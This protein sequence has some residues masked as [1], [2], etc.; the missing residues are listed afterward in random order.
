MFVLTLTT[1]GVNGYETDKRM[2]LLP[3]ARHGARHP[4]FPCGAIIRLNKRTT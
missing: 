4:T 3:A 1:D 2:K